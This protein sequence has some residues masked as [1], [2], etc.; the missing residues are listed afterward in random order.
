MARLILVTGPGHGHNEF[1]SWVL[2]QSHYV[3][4]DFNPTWELYP[5]PFGTFIR[6]DDSWNTFKDFPEYSWMYNTEI[7]NGINNLVQEHQ[8]VRL[9]DA[10]MDIYAINNK[11]SQYINCLNPKESISFARKHDITTSTAI[12]DLPNS[13]HRSHYVQMEFSIGA[14]STKDYGMMQFSLKEVCFWL[15][16]KHRQ[17]LTEIINANADYPANVNNL[18][19]DDHDVVREE[20]TRAMVMSGMNPPDEATDFRDDVYKKI[21]YFKFINQPI[22]PLMKQIND[23]SWDDI[24]EEAQKY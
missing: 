20:I 2:N 7:R 22:H 14:A 21:D 18:L 9:R 15:T 1:L 17:Q 24:L 10:V 12:I 11:I 8:I 4:N 19:S 13:K 23:M 5:G 6:H 3:N 16:K